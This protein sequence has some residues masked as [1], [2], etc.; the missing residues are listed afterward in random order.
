MTRPTTSLGSLC[1]TPSAACSVALLGGHRYESVTFS[2]D[3]LRAMERLYECDFQRAEQDGV[4][5]AA[6]AHAKRLAEHEEALAEYAK[7]RRRNGHPPERPA[8]PDPA[9]IARWQR[10]GGERNV[11]RR[12]AEDGL[13]MI[14]A[15]AR[16]LQPGE[17]PVRA[18]C[19][20]MAQA[21]WD[22]AEA[23]E[24]YDCSGTDEGE[25]P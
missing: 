25:G 3:E 9:A 20:L 18:L 11:F 21:G 2:R 7:G 13:R 16:H 17:D 4:A 22:V 14:A 8:A 6:A 19:A 12:V 1:S 5:F 23:P 24:W 10:S 15:I